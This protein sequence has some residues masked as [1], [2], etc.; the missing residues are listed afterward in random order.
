M[1]L[2]SFLRNLLFGRPVE[3]AP[4]SAATK[5]APIPVAKPTSPLTVG[6]SRQALLTQFRFRS[7]NKN[8][9]QFVET[10]TPAYD[11]AFPTPSGRFF[12]L[13][14]DGDRSRLDHLGLPVFSTPRELAGWLQIPLGQL[15]WLTHRASV[16]SRPQTPSE[17]HYH[18]R[19]IRKRSGGYRLIEAPKTLLRSIQRRILEEILNR[20]AAHS[21]A[22]G[23]V[24]G[25]SIVTNAREH[26][27]QRF[28]L[29]FDLENFYPTV[30]YKRVVAIFRAL[31]YSREAAI[32]LSRLTTSMIPTDLP[33]PD[34]NPRH[35]VPYFGRHLPQ[36]APTSPALANL[37]AYVLDLRLAG[38]A[39]AWGMTYTRYADDLTFSGPGKSA[40]ALKQFIP[41]AQQVIRQERF[42]LNKAKRKVI[43][44]SQRM[45]VTGVVVNEKANVCREDFDR[46]KAILHNCRK[47]GAVSQNRD[48]HPSFSEHLRGRIAHVT[49]LNPQKGAKLLAVFVQIR[50]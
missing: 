16:H 29:K 26:V 8:L 14:Q 15:V 41:L 39:R 38:L 42:R 7:K 32:W 45:Q 47:Y 43:R 17:A 10:K 4:D 5:T 9:G 34:Q 13:S 33:A 2:L 23:F 20:V 50:W 11:Y 24:R 6:G 12:D 35:I 36:G 44:K 25:R 40:A 21:A 30:R 37:S 1:G 3:A 48:S 18:F 31:G 49:Q 46:L 28:L 19:W 27:G 22:H